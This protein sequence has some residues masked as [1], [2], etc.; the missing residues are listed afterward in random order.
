MALPLVDRVTDRAQP[1][2]RLAGAGYAAVAPH[3]STATESWVAW[4]RGSRRGSPPRPV[5]RYQ[6]EL[7]E[8]AGSHPRREIARLS[9]LASAYRRSGDLSEA[10]VCAARAVEAARD[11][12]D[13]RLVGLTLNG[14]G[15]VQTLHPVVEPALVSL[16]EARELFR[17]LGD[18]QIEGQVLANLGGVYARLGDRQAARAV[19][20]EA[21][22]L[23]APDSSAHE[24]LAAWL[25]EHPQADPAEDETAEGP[26]PPAPVAGEHDDDAI[27]V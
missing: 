7:R 25:A 17:R 18:S 12:G 13:E 3:F 9:N 20:A 27:A 11:L 23:L 2:R 8:A 19:W 6:D 22:G 26:L 16:T 4:A 24:K 21:L 1:L 10:Q 15:L 5:E 14:L